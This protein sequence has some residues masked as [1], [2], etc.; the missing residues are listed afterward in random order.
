MKSPATQQGM[1]DLLKW[2]GAKKRGCDIFSEGLVTGLDD[3]EL[4]ELRGDGY[5]VVTLEEGLKK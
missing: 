2:L 3:A 5:E 1:Y 4:E